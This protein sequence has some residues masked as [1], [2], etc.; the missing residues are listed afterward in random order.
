MTSE[1]RYA[2]VPVDELDEAHLSGTFST[3]LSAVVRYGDVAVIPFEGR[4]PSGLYGRTTLTRAEH[5]AWV[6]AW[7]EEH[8]P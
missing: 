3:D 1:T 5:M 4:K 8:I 2:Y 7:A 6:R